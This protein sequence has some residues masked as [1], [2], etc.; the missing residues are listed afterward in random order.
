MRQ[1]SACDF[2]GENAAGTFEVLPAGVDGEDPKRMVLCPACEATLSEVIDPL[3]DTLD[4]T[5]PLVAEAEPA[6]VSELDTDS[7][8]E[9]DEDET[10][11]DPGPDPDATADGPGATEPSEPRSSSGNTRSRTPRGY[12]KVMKFLEGREFPIE[13]EAV[14]SMAAEAYGMDPRAVAAAIDHAAKH[15]RIQVAGRKLLR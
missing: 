5:E 6:V 13:R 12:S 3:L 8:A 2:C 4:G 14:E 1:V 10:D 11:E 9:A 15:G 7:A